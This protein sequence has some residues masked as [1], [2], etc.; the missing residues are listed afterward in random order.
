[1][2]KKSITRARLDAIRLRLGGGES[3]IR[4]EAQRLALPPAELKALLYHP[5]GRQRPRPQQRRPR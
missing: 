1:M 5:E 2:K 4:V 3:C